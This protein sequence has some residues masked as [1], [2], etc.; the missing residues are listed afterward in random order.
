MLERALTPLWTPFSRSLLL[1]YVSI[2]IPYH[3]SRL[4]FHMQLNYL[5]VDNP[6][7]NGLFEWFDVCRE[8]GVP[9]FVWETRRWTTTLSSSSTSAPTSPTLTTHP[10]FAPEPPSS[11]SP[12]RF[13]G[14]LYRRFPFAT[15]FS[16]SLFERVWLYRRKDLRSNYCR[17]LFAERGLSWKPKRTRWLWRCVRP[18]NPSVLFWPCLYYFSSH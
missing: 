8:A 15:I 17:S 12:S 7:L 9:L 13:L 3:T 2:A 1:R 14:Y 5:S 10:K 18:Q 6:L 16:V 11:T 4:P